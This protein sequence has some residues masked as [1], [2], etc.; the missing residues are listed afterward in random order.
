M[1]LRVIIIVASL[2][3]GSCSFSS[4]ATGEWQVLVSD[5]IFTYSPSN[6]R[7]VYKSH[8][9][10]RVAYVGYLTSSN[11]IDITK[12]DVRSGDVLETRTIFDNWG[13]NSSGTVIGDDHANPSVIELR[14]QTDPSDNGK[15]LV[16]AAEHGSAVEGRGRLSVTRSTK[17]VSIFLWDSAVSILER[18]AT[19]PRLVETVTGTIFLF[20]RVSERQAPNSRASFAYWTSDD[21][22]RM[23]SEQRFLVDAGSLGDDT[24]Y[25][26]FDYDESTDRIHAAFNR[27]A[28]DDPA[29]GVWRYQDVFYGYVDCQ[30]EVFVSESDCEFDMPVYLSDIQPIYDTDDTAGAEDWTFVSD[31]VAHDG[32]VTIV[33]LNVRDRGSDRPS[34]VGWSTDV[35]Y[36]QKTS[37]EWTVQEVGSSDSFWYP[38]MAAID[39]TNPNRVF[40]M[41]DRIDGGSYLVERVVSDATIADRVL[42]ES[43]FGELA[44]PFVIPG[45]R[46]TYRVFMNLIQEYAGSPYID[47]D[48]RVIGL[49]P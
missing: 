4:D 24:V 38:S 35:L 33:S 43:A 31:I 11:T 9:D 20:C 30:N 3:L 42:I 10:D 41:I 7:P 23:W 29:D 36:H 28:Y 40:F 37:T 21:G 12:I 15:I 49:V 44:R 34:N 26:F 13:W 46:G 39:P 5:G 16:A 19:Y 8:R 47:W 25:A 32:G 6:S 2:V 45:Q 18:Y 22:G 1:Y 17:P 48:S 27:L 14:W